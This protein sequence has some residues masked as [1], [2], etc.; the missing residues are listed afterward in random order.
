ML[1]SLVLLRTLLWQNYSF[2]TTDRA[3][4]SCFHMWHIRSYLSSRSVLTLASQKS[5]GINQRSMWIFSKKI[6][7]MEYPGNEG[8]HSKDPTGRKSL[9]LRALSSSKNLVL[10]IAHLLNGKDWLLGQLPFISVFMR[11]SKSEWVTQKC[12]I[13]WLQILK[14]YYLGPVITDS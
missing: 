11:G 9:C 8:K 14:G 7:Q 2:S 5:N 1:L 4:S 12:L 3:L 13:I 10:A 6:I